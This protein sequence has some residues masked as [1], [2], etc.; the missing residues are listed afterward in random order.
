MGLGLDLS[1]ETGQIEEGGLMKDW[2]RV[3]ICEEEMGLL[4]GGSREVCLSAEI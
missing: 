2:L 4:I 1:W 3:E